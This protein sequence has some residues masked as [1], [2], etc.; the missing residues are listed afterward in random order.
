LD[1][2]ARVRDFL[3][4]PE[5]LDGLRKATTEADGVIHLAFKHD[6]ASSGD[7]SA[8]DL[9]AIEAVGSA[10]QSTDKHLQESRVLRVLHINLRV[11]SQV[12]MLALRLEGLR[13]RDGNGLRDWERAGVHPSCSRGGS[14]QA[15]IGGWISG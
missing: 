14:A 11:A 1:A 3:D 12:N 15:V 9:D 6:L 13:T 10:L 5:Y 8:P 7:A 4:H 2:N